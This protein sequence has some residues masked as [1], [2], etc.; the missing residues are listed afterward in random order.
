MLASNFKEYYNKRRQKVMAS[1]VNDY[2][3]W[4]EESIDK[5]CF[6]DTMN[7]AELAMNQLNRLFYIHVDRSEMLLAIFG[8]T[9]ETILERLITKERAGYDNYKVTI[10]NQLEIGYSSTINDEYEKNG[11]FVCGIK[12]LGNSGQVE[13]APETSDETIQLC[14]EWNSANIVTDTNFINKVV[15]A[16][17]VKLKQLKCFIGSHELI[18]P[19]FVEVYKMAAQYAKIKRAENKDEFAYSINFLN[20]FD[21]TARESIDGDDEIL[22]T[23]SISSKL[24]LKNDWLASGKFETPAQEQ[25]QVQIEE[26]DILPFKEQDNKEATEQ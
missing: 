4:C 16:T 18:I 5:S 20:C 25:D 7:I 3:E 1:V 2:L 21:I 15:E 19:I 24:E 6:D 22:I 11:G 9:Y 10:A 23:P 14:V 8:L 26:Q 17:A 13:D 12:D